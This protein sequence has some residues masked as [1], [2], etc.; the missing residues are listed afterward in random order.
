VIENGRS[1]AV[2]ITDEPSIGVDSP[3]DADRFEAHLERRAP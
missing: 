3:E 2:G 1:I